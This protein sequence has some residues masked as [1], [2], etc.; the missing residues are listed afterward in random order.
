MAQGSYQ[1][2]SAASN[3][4]Q[5][6]S[7]KKE[8][9]T[10]SWLNHLSRPKII[11][12]SLIVLLTFIALLVVAIYPATKSERRQKHLQ[13]QETCGKSA[14]EARSLGCIFDIILLGWAPWHCHNVALASEFLER[15]DWEFFHSPNDIV[16]LA[17]EEV[18]MGEWD[19]LYIS[20]EFYILNCMYAWRKVREAAKSGEML[21]GYLA[22]EHQTNHCEM[23]MLRRT[24][25]NNTATNVYTK[26]VNCAGA[27][28][29]DGRFGWYRMLGGR[30]TYRQP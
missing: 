28:G 5:L 22:D 13:E 26:F 30:K 14:A 8:Q 25:L 2:L 6:P 17:I 23:M 15:Q 18:M 10:T 27:H 20:H 24:E 29:Y 1:L 16:P 3:S 4:N 9:H 12:G 21:D 19:T 7:E 11:S